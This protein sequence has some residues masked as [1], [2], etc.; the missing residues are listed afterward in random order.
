MFIFI[1]FGFEELS[2]C[3]IDPIIVGNEGEKV[4]LIDDVIN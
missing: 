2:L 4:G 3:L 1:W